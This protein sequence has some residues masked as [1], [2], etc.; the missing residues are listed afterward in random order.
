MNLILPID[1][2]NYEEILINAIIVNDKLFSKIREGTWCS[3]R[4]TSKRIYDA[5]TEAIMKKLL[6]HQILH[7]RNQRRILRNYGRM[8]DTS[9]MGSG[10]TYTSCALAKDLNVNLTVFSL[11]NTLVNW[12]NACNHFGIKLERLTFYPYNEFLRKEKRF[13]K[14]LD[15]VD[16]TRHTIE[17]QSTHYQ[18]DENWIDTVQKGTLLILDECHFLKNVSGRSSLAIQLSQALFKHNIRERSYVLCLSATPFDKI[19]HTVRLARV[20]NII[21]KRNLTTTIPGGYSYSIRYE[22]LQELIDYCENNYIGEKPKIKNY[23]GEHQAQRIAYEY[24]IKMLKPMLFC[25]MPNIQLTFKADTINY[26]CNLHSITD[27]K[28]VENGVALL[29]RAIKLY[30]TKG[31]TLSASEALSNIQQGLTNI[32]KGKITIFINQAKQSLKL[33]PNMKVIIM[34]NYRDTIKHVAEGLKEFNPL[35]INGKTPMDKRPDMIANFQKPDTKYRVLICNL[36]ILAQGLDLDDK[37]GNFPRKMFISPSYYVCN[38]HQATGRVL[39]SDTKSQPIIRF[40]YVAEVNKEL[41]L[42]NRLAKK[43]QMIQSGLKYKVLLPGDYPQK[44][45]TKNK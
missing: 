35:V 31:E 38:L 19:E 4:Q 39:R 26:F 2:T 14:K 18:V 36:Q 27:L 20:F 34:L 16:E 28:Y 30:E 17:E 13:F 42:L 45:Q 29:E 23:H 10:K 25:A 7:F 44:Y 3:L 6:P 33:N 40:I 24:I 1:H 37:N 41:D 22:G 15:V 9:L 8:L 43:S 5:L 32:E 12:Q 11:P 21:T